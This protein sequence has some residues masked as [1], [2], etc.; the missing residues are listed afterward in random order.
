MPYEEISEDQ[1][2]LI[3]QKIKKV[4]LSTNQDSVGEMYCDSESCTK[5]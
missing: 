2:N 1:Y 5:I 3:N 4:E